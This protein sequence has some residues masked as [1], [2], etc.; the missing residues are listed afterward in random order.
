MGLLSK[1]VS[2]EIPPAS[3]E[4]DNMGK[5]LADR[6][7]S[8]S[9]PNPETAI[10]L[11]KAYGS[12]RAGIGLSQKRDVYFSYA[13]VGVG[14]AVILPV[15]QLIPVPGQG[16]YSANYHPQISSIPR[17]T[18]FWAFPLHEFGKQ[19][20]QG[21]LPAHIL[22]VGEDRNYI[23]QPG[24]IQNLLELAGRAFLP[25]ETGGAGQELPLSK[26]TA[27]SIEIILEPP[28]EFVEYDSK[29]EEIPVSVITEGLL[30]RASRHSSSNVPGEN[31]EDKVL[32]KELSKVLAKFGS[33]QGLV[34][35]ASG[36]DPAGKLASIVS[37]FGTVSLVKPDFCILLFSGQLDG[38]LL[39]HHLGIVPG[40]N[41]FRFEA[42]DPQ[43][44]LKALK[45]FM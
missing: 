4:L 27:E 21:E 16:Y 31:E 32:V 10:S 30:K 13:L 18:K 25:P 8:L 24:Q 43:E 6:L 29:P 15:D 23:F 44:A 2:N 22:L 20:L 9:Q 33:I 34:F 40:K 36:K 19:G 14:D 3:N 37:G 39:A 11:L 12:F 42:A 28:G 38:E 35:H 26:E 1:A 45:S 7:L 41:L 5:A 17:D